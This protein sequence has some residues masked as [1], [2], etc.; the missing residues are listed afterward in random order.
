MVGFSRPQSANTAVRRT[1]GRK[2]ATSKSEGTILLGGQRPTTVQHASTKK[3]GAAAMK[4]ARGGRTAKK[5]VL[6]WYRL[7]ATGGW[8]PSARAVSVFTRRFET[9]LRTTGTLCSRRLGRK[10][11]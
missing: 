11:L 10:S 5:R 4:A 1:A 3:N 7:P 2:V 6:N 9:Q 8:V